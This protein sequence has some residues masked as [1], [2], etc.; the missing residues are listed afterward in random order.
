MFVVLIYKY[1][2]YRLVVFLVRENSSH[3]DDAYCCVLT[4]SKGILSAFL[5]GYRPWD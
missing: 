4:L 1:A 5:R 2:L 3:E